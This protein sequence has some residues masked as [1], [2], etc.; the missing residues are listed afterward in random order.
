MFA[1]LLVALSQSPLDAILSDP[2]LEGAL[3]AATVTDLEGKVLYE[4]NASMR[5]V[6]ASNQKLLSN[7]FALYAM[8]PSYRPETKIWKLMDRTVVDSPGDPLLSHRILKE[9]RQR[10]KLNRFL[11][12][13]VREAYAPGVPASWEVDDLPNKY[14]APITAFTVDRG[15]FELWNVAGKPVFRPDAYG[16]KIERENG[17]V[18]AAPRISYDPFSRRVQ[19]VGELPK[20]PEVRLDTLALPK[21]DEAAARVLGIR[22]FPTELVP[23]RMPD[24]IIMGSPTS[25]M[26]KACLPP[27][28]N[29]IAE[30]L[31][32][33]GAKA[34]GPL[35][36][37]PYAAAR[38]R[39]TNFLTG[40]VGVRKEDFR[41][42]DGSGMS[43]HNLVTV[44][45]MAQLLAWQN[46]QSTRGVWRAALARPGI[47][48]LAAR[49]QGLTFEGKTGSLDMVI[50]LSGYVRVADGSE[51]IVSVI[52]NHFTGSA[53][54]ARNI[55]DAFVKQV[56][57][58]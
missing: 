22:M 2:K 56:S 19:I 39:M 38:D 50:A 42:Y 30:H 37:D 48:T 52:L 9:A 58:S 55:A 17:T 44:R 54:D 24:L 26:I 23:D 45:G 51:R 41:I 34:Q 15:S 10:L 53:T 31:F 21:P 57:L 5:V 28:D 18:G 25:D 35:T 1:P 4:H 32:L 11:P 13:Y 36:S 20:V 40:T 12:V 47:G 46:R 7:A 14:A 49:M 43:R 29:N 6:P 3:V 8:G 27:S 16:T 33:L